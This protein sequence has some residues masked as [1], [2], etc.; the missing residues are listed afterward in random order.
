[1]WR[2]PVTLCSIQFISISRIRGDVIHQR[3]Y[4]PLLCSPPFYSDKMITSQT[5]VNTDNTLGTHICFRWAQPHEIESHIKG[6]RPNSLR[7][8]R[9]SSYKTTKALIND[10]LNNLSNYSLCDKTHRRKWRTSRTLF[11]FLFFLKYKFEIS[12]SLSLWGQLFFIFA[13]ATRGN[14]EL[15]TLENHSNY[16][17]IEL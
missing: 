4:N 17:S 1:M 11:L 3:V 14:G 13:F 16:D 2:T 5:R 6:I 15:E 9:L 8:T 12:T 10:K 7:Q